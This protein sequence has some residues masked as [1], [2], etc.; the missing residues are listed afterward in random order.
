MKDML[1]N[2]DR[3]QAIR[4]VLTFLLGIVFLIAVRFVLYT[5][6]SVH[7]HANFA[8]FVNGEREQFDNFTFYEEIQSCG[9]DNLNNPKIRVHMH[10][11]INHVVH[12]HDDASTWGHLFAN[13]GMTAGDTLFKTVEETYVKGVDDTELRYLLNGDEVQTIANRTI[14]SEDVLLIS[15][16]SPTDEIMQEQYS[17]ITQDAGEY[18]ERADPSACTGGKEKGLVERLKIATG[19]FDE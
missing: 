15:I 11:Q 16:G 9:G 7:Y 3:K 19:L 1:E 13:I 18:N 12:V 2:I 5:D 10:D 17:E 6:D 14:E 4:A 8:V